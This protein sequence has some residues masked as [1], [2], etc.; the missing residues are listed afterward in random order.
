M[1][2]STLTNTSGLLPGSAPVFPTGAGPK[3]GSFPITCPPDRRHGSGTNDSPEPRA[4]VVIIEALWD[5]QHHPSSTVTGL[6]LAVGVGRGSER[7]ARP[8]VSA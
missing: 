7:V 1:M 8:D 3:R 5:N 2:P 4:R 6:Y